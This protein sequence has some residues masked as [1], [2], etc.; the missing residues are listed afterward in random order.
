MVPEERNIIRRNIKM[1]EEITPKER[2][3][4]INIIERLVK[5]PLEERDE[6]II[7][8]VARNL[9]TTAKATL[10]VSLV[11]VG[12]NSFLELI[13]S[14]MC[15]TTQSYPRKGYTSVSRLAKG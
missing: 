7:N 3:V 1:V 12:K 13:T 8:I 10:K 6:A 9:D 2:A 5:L 11:I 14:D 4:I 15:R